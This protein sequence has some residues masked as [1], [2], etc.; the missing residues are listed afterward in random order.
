[1]SANRK[2]LLVRADFVLGR[3]RGG[4]RLVYRRW[5]RV[6]TDALPRL[7]GCADRTPHAERVCL[8]KVEGE[9]RFTGWVRLPVERH[10]KRRRLRKFRNALRERLG[11]GLLPIDGQVVKVGV[12]R[13]RARLVKPVLP[14]ADVQPQPIAA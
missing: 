4:D 7:L 12:R 2:S 6:L 3:G 14:V 13:C 11:A 8:H 5:R 9:G 10:P 1:L